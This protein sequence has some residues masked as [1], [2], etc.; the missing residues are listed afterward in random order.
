MKTQ[1]GVQSINR[2]LNILE[3]LAENIDGSSLTLLSKKTGL[4]VSTAHRLVNTLK[5]RGYIEQ[6][7]VTGKYSL[8]LKLFE[9]GI[10]KLESIDLR[11]LAKP[12]MNELADITQETVHLVILAKDEG[13]YIDKVEAKGAIRLHSQ[14]G[15]RLP[16]HATA[17]GKILLTHLPKD[18]VTK[19]I[20]KKRQYSYARNT[21]TD[22]K[23]LK[24][25]LEKIRLQ[26]Y[27]LDEEEYQDGV[28]SV[29]VP[30]KDHTGEVVASMSLSAP[31]S[32]LKI[33]GKTISLIKKYGLKISTQLG[34]IEKPI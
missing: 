12:L 34:Y 9:I 1:T 14:I 11:Q 5:K 6:N 18:E 15:W 3:I 28:T 21:I 32:R 30:I 26:G 10:K 20:K 23:T 13:V 8:G 24:K 33:D 16:L 22:L 25:E 2:S 7:E 29:A 17:T 4:H 19:I 31:V 27:S